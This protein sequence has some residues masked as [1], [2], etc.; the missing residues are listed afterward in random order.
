[1]RDLILQLSKSSIYSTK[2]ICDITNICNS[3]RKYR[4]DFFQIY[5]RHLKH[6]HLNGIRSSCSCIRVS[7]KNKSNFSAR[8]YGI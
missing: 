4:N 5:F 8:V 3:Q 6:L 1:M 2:P 7:R